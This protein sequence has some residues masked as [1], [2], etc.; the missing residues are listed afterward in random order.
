MPDRAH[1]P[2]LD[3]WEKTQFGY[4]GK[5]RAFFLD[6]LH[7]RKNIGTALL[8]AFEETKKHFRRKGHALEF[9]G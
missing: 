6:R 5:T 3:D 7:D 1:A 8:L 9:L 4:G 2:I